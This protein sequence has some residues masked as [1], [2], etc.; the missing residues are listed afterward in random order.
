[1]SKITKRCWNIILDELEE[2]EWYS[3]PADKYREMITDLF[4]NYGIIEIMEDENNEGIEKIVKS[5]EQ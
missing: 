4:V 1:M 5:V 3:L 2:I